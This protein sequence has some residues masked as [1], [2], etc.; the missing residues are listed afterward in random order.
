MIILNLAHSPLLKPSSLSLTSKERSLFSSLNN[1]R[2]LK[3]G[4][5]AVP[6]ETKLNAS[7]KNQ[8]ISLAS[9]IGIEDPDERE[10]RRSSFYERIV[11]SIISFSTSVASCSW[12]AIRGLFMGIFSTH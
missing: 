8:Y 6:A 7:M 12:Q 1:Y 9:L 5:A 2:Y 4:I 3:H 11:G 10:A